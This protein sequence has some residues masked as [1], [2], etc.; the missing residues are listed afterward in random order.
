MRVFPIAQLRI[1]G[2]QLVVLFGEIRRHPYW[3]KYVTGGT[4]REFKDSCRFIFT[5]CFLLEVQIVS[6]Q[7]PLQ[8]PCLLLV[9]TPA[10][11]DSCPSRIL[12]QISHFSTLPWSCD[13]NRK[14]TGTAS[15]SS[16]K[17]PG[18]L[19]QFSLL[20]VSVREVE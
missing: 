14:V 11:T 10:T 18:S 5:P 15:Q 13:C 1:F 20:T 2:S 4:L 6:P 12:S 16:C 7:L 19:L 8:R 3:R 9:A 17:T